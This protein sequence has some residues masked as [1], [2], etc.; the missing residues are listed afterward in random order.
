[1]LLSVTLLLIKSIMIL[2]V[3]LNGVQDIDREWRRSENPEA[4]D[5]DDA[6]EVAE[7]KAVH[8]EASMKFARRSVR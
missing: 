6:D 7:I 5:E 2:H 8:F 1:M 4:M 3:F